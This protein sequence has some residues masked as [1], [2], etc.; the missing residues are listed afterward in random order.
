MSVLSHIGSWYTVHW[1]GGGRGE[2]PR[3]TCERQGRC[4]SLSHR[5]HYTLWEGVRGRCSELPVRDR[6]R[7]C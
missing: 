1:G 2:M 3:V 5:V 6:G 4:V 7:R